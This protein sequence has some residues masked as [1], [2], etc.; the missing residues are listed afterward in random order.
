M[1]SARVHRLAFLGELF[2]AAILLL[3]AFRSC[4]PL[5]DFCKASPNWSACRP[6]RDSRKTH[7]SAHAAFGDT[8]L[9][10]LPPWCP[11]KDVFFRR[12]CPGE[13]ADEAARFAEHLE[14]F[15]KSINVY[16]CVQPKMYSFIFGFPAPR[17]LVTEVKLTASSNYLFT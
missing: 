2:D 5:D 10:G 7:R 12:P 4:K 9:P 11:Q 1:C 14:G 8:L 3:M 15:L 13:F 17:S 6:A 16:G